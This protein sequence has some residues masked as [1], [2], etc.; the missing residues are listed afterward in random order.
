[1][2]TKIKA[3]Q[4]MNPEIQ[5]ILEM[6][7]TKRKPDFQMF[8]NGILKFR[9]RLCVPDDLELKE[10]ILS[11]AHRSKYSIH[12]GSTKMYQNLRQYYWWNGMKVDVA[13]HVAKCLTCQ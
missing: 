11:E 13:K 12:P 10:E 2:Q 9:G 1:M 4:S 6:D 8:E 7:G 5:K 3:L